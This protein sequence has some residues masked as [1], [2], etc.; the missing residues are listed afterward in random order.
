MKKPLIAPKAN[1]ICPAPL[2]LSAFLEF[3]CEKTSVFMTICTK[4]H[5]NPFQLFG[6]RNEPTSQISGFPKWQN[7]IRAPQKK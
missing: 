1:Q 3:R 5:P 2:T 6:L 4:H 7:E